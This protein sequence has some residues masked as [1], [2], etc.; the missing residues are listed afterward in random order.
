MHC[1]CTYL[2]FSS[3]IHYNF[4]VIFYFIFIFILSIDETDS[5]LNRL[6]V[7]QQ[8]DLSKRSLLSVEQ[9]IS[10]L[11]THDVDGKGSNK[12]EHLQPCKLSV[13]RW[14]LRR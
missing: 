6:D 2:D 8:T 3:N 14:I 13:T 11:D 12:H 4:I 1:F 9:H 7:L 5:N 10:K